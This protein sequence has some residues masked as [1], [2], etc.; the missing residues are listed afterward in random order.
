M[1]DVFTVLTVYNYVKKCRSYAEWQGFQK[2]SLST[3]TFN[4]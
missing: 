2:M 1:Y 4:A 3:T